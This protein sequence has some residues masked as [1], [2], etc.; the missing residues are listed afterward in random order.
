[1]EGII[2]QLCLLTSGSK[3]SGRLVVLGHRCSTILLSLWLYRRVK[4]FI[5]FKIVTFCQVFLC[6]CMCQKPQDELRKDPK[7]WI[8][9]PLVTLGQAIKYSVRQVAWVWVY[10][11]FLA[12]CT[13]S[14]DRRNPLIDRSTT[15]H[16]GCFPFQSWHSASIFNCV[17]L[18]KCLRNTIQFSLCSS[19][20]VRDSPQSVRTNQS[21]LPLIP[22]KVSC[23]FVLVN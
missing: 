18:V 12:T 14:L 8:S 1:M 23:S 9:L 21:Q 11:R 7:Y 22:S 3:I 17:R 2:F 6:L 20:S 13:A 16:Y 10:S 19:L 5:G 15:W 4:S